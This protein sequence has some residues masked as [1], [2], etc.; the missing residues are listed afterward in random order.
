LGKQ[1]EFAANSDVR[2][3]NPN[4]VILHSEADDAVP[5]A[6]GQE[7]LRN[8]GLP[9]SALIVVGTDHRLADLESLA[10][11]LQVVEVVAAH[12]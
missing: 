7:L 10:K 11:M 3:A 6:D 12:D 1:V 9:E 4:T 8:S 2:T 5:F